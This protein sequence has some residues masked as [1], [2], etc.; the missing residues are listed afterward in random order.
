MAA[1]LTAEEASLV[2]FCARGDGLQGSAPMRRCFDFQVYRAVSAE[3]IWHYGTD[4]TWV[5]KIL[6]WQQVCGQH[7]NTLGTFHDA[8][9]ELGTYLP[10]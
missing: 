10:T 5:V 4:L 9:L 3:S 2:A 8:K 1:R 7:L 6:N